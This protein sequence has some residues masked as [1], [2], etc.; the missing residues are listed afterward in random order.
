MKVGYYPGCA[1]HGSSN[2]YEYSV[3]NCFKALGIEL[4]ELSDWLCCGATAAHSINQKLAVALPARNLAIAERDGLADLLAPC[5]MCSMELLKAKE[6]LADA[7]V[8]AEMSEIVEL[9]VTG[10]TRITNLIQVFQAYGVDK[11]AARQKVKLDS[12]K[13]ACYYG[14]LLTRPPKTLRFDEYESPTGMEA[15]LKALGADPVEW[16]Y[17]TECCGAGMTLCDKDTVVDLGYKILSNAL[18]HGATSLVVAC[19]MCET[20]L[21]M[22]QGDIEKKY[23]KKIGLPIYYLSDLVSL[24][25]GLPESQTSMPKHFVRK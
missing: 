12:F 2:D 1:L 5:P 13:P 16:N 9:P 6:K 22:R 3:R 10:S 14:C 21:D 25:L 7:A 20:N 11:I 24:A 23:N 19:P 8:R 18:E 17:K 15:I 4:E